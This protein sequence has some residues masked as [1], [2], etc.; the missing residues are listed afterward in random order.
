MAY[1]KYLLH[2]RT[3]VFHSNAVYKN[4][5]NLGMKRYYLPNK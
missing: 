4:I 2:V 5:N 3:T 1:W